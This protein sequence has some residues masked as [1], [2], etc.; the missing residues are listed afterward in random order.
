[1]AKLCVDIQIR[2][3]IIIDT[4]F[5]IEFSLF[6][7]LYCLSSQ[8][9]EKIIQ[10]RATIQIQFKSHDAIIMHPYTHSHED[11]FST[12]KLVLLV[13]NSITPAAISY[14]RLLISRTNTTHALFKRTTYVYTSYVRAP[15]A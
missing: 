2:E 13:G 5:A 15:H 9:P 7:Y 14:L 12:E 4:Y 10:K 8:I 11:P 3:K 1:M 6:D